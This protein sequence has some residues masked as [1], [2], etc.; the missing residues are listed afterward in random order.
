MQN[1][2]T[3]SDTQLQLLKTILADNP[4]DKIL[5]ADLT[6]KDILT[7]INN[8]SFSINDKK[9]IE[10]VK[11]F[12]RLL[13]IIPKENWDIAILLLEVNM[14]S[15]IQIA[16]M[17]FDRFQEVTRAIFNENEKLARTIHSNALLKRSKI[18]LQYMDIYQ[19][20]EPHVKSARL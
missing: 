17:P 19:N 5:T 2:K 14:H 7:Q 20:N 11:A 15:A 6:K 1:K 3:F 4:P 12:Q 10:I 9:S 13:R 8:S 16:N 18:V